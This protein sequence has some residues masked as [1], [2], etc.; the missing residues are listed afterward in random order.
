MIHLICSDD[1][2]RGNLY[3]RIIKYPA[4]KH[5]KEIHEA[6]EEHI[7]YF[8]RE[9]LK[10]THM[11]L[12]KQQLRSLEVYCE[13]FGYLNKVTSRFVFDNIRLH[14]IHGI[15]LVQNDEV[16]ILDTHKILYFAPEQHKMFIKYI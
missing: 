16:F 3:Q 7:V 6:I 8:K 15:Y 5:G 10:V 12:N 14:T 13:K 4:W 1:G 9:E 11:F 2:P